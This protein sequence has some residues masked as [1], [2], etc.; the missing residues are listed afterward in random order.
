MSMNKPLLEC[1]AINHVY[2]E[3]TLETPV[4]KGIDL[5]VAQGEML[6]VVGSSGSGKSTLLHLLGAL[7]TPTSGKVLF[8]GQDI[9]GWSSGEQARFRNRELGFVYQFH[10]LLSEFSALE[11]AAMPL[12]IGGA[13]V[14][15][16]SDKAAAMLARVGLSHR[17]HH[18]PSELSGGERQRVAIARALVGE[19]SLVLADE[20]TGN[21]DHASATAVYELLC[22]L[23]RELGTAF[24]VVTHD[25]GLAAKLHRRVTLVSGVMA[26]V[27]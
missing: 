18:R 9:H 25:L 10:H 14:K 2:R 4:L 1:L 16:A 7:D 19:P 23:N 13:S 5:S 27:A 15:E 24:V 22:E 8:R 17:L 21:L 3:G 12:L 11:N 6:A 26:E 20:P